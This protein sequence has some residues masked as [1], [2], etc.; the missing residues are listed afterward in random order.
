VVAGAVNFI[1]GQ[2]G[3]R[4][5]GNE[6]YLMLRPN[7]PGQDPSQAADTTIAGVKSRRSTVLYKV[8]TGR[9]PAPSGVPAERLP[10]E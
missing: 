8:R 5:E 1:Y 7:A 3:P 10:K 2:P 9:A 4:L 6:R